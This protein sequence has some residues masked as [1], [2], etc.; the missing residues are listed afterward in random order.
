VDYLG[1]VWRGTRMVRAS[2]SVPLA[3]REGRRD[4]RSLDRDAARSICSAIPRAR[5]AGDRVDV[6]RVDQMGAQQRSATEADEVV[7]QMSEPIAG[8][9]HAEPLAV[10]G[11][12]VRGDRVQQVDV[13]ADHRGQLLRDDRARAR[14]RTIG[15]RGHPTRDRARTSRTMSSHLCVEAL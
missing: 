11:A 8:D 5:D 4:A 7:S 15:T 2:G 9:V 12:S 10:M 6:S 13:L 3:H 1:H 14:C